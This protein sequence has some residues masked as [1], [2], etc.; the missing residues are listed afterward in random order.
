MMSRR[1]QALSKALLTLALAEV[2]A[3]AGVVRA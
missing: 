3:L 1:D 2:E